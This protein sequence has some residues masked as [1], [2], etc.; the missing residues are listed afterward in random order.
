[1]W[2]FKERDWKY[3]ARKRIEEL[4]VE[5]AMQLTYLEARVKANPLR[6]DFARQLATNSLRVIRAQRQELENFLKSN[7]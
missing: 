4:R 6:E 7:S 2:P 5:E 1:M 3:R